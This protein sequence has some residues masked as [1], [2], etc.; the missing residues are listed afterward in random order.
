MG[1]VSVLAIAL[2][3]ATAVALQWSYFAFKE[4]ERG[5]VDSARLSKVLESKLKDFDELKKQVDTLSLK[6]G[7]R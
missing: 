7:L 4:K 1:S 3:C 6:V 2:I 5:H